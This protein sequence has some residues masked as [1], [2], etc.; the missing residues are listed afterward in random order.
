MLVLNL[1]AIQVHNCIKICVVRFSADLDETDNQIAD[2]IT[3]FLFD[4]SRVGASFIVVFYTLPIFLSV[5]VPLILIYSL[6]YVCSFGNLA[7]LPINSNITTISYDSF[8]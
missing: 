6:V 1:V 2:F 4:L 3:A 7:C 5:L 8:A